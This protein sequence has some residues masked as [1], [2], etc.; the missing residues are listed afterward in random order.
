ML[1]FGWA[2]ER[3]VNMLSKGSA[4]K[5]TIFLNV[6]TQH[7]F[8][9]LYESILT[10]LMHKGVAGATATRALAGFGA[11]RLLHT[12]KVEML[13]EHLPIRVEF[14]ETAQ[15]VEELL[16]AL[17]DMVTDGLIEVQDTTVV[18]IAMKDKRRQEPKQPHERKA[19]KA[20]LMRIFLGEADRRNG[21]PLYD[22]IVNRLRMMDIAGATVYKGILGYGAK[23][24]THKHNLLH[25][26]RDL[27]IMISVVETEEKLRQAAE[28]V[29]EMLEDGLIAISDVDIVRLV[30][31]HPPLETATESTNAKLP[32]S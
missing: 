4:K 24:H 8:T 27:P 2:E 9:T 15:K 7:H 3:S 12:P 32:A 14:I 11:H 16:P 23:G 30:H 28:A 17:Y 6:D 21:E 1:L 31:T 13:A 10:F 5:V 19:G 29:E 20:K 22:A 18:K 25:T 26:N